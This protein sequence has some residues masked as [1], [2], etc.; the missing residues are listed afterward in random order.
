[1]L[2]VNC[3]CLKPKL[4]LIAKNQGENLQTQQEIIKLKEFLNNKGCNLSV[5]KNA[6]KYYSKDLK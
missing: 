5:V 3:T 6:M 4:V 1:M 2:A